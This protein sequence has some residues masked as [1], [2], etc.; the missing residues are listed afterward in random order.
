MATSATK[1]NALLAAFAPGSSVE[2]AM[3][4]NMIQIS[5]TK[6]CYR[7]PTLPDAPAAFAITGEIDRIELPRA[8]CLRLFEVLPAA[9]TEQSRYYLCGVFLQTIQDALFS[10][11]TNGVQLLRVGVVADHFS[12]DERLIVPAPAATMMRRLLRGAKA[13]SVTMRRS[14][15]LLSVTAPGSFE[16]VT[17]LIDASYPD[18]RESCRTLPAILSPASARN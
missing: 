12:D 14:R 4:G 11:A 6:S 17:A 2:I 3:N 16:L 7:L 8:D 10:V 5:S 18:Y 13:D 15:G 9:G 1:L